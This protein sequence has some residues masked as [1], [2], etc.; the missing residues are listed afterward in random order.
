MSEPG[1]DTASQRIPEATVN[2]WLESSRNK[3]KARPVVKPGR[4]FVKAPLGWLALA[5]ALPG[6]ALAVGLALWFLRGVKRKSTVR[7]TIGTL[8]KFRIER[9][10][11]YRALRQLEDA[12]LVEVTRRQGRGPSV[13]ILDAPADAPSAD[14]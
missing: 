4:Q 2:G 13:T 11:C 14:P 9:R 8:E 6:K 7:L 10:A 5:G 1:F 12:R 3:P